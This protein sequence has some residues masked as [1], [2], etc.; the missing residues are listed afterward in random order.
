MLKNA[1]IALVMTIGLVASPAFTA[2]DDLSPELRVLDQRVGTWKVETVV[3]P[4]VWVPEGAKTTGVETIEWT[5]GK[6]FIKGEAKVENPRGKGTNLHLM[7]YDPHEGVYKFWYFDSNGEFPRSDMK[8]TYD[9]KLNTITYKSVLPNDVSVV[10]VTKFENKDRLTWHG[11][12]KDKDGQLM[13]EIDG[14]VTRIKEKD[15]K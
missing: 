14:V 13:M 5:L 3:K 11:V 9:Q 6:K 12:W 1:M 2:D 15:E 8:G 10:I 7:T 4:G